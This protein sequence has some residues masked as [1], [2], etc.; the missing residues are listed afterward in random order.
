MWLCSIRVFYKSFEGGA[1]PSQTPV[2]SPTLSKKLSIHTAERFPSQNPKAFSKINQTI[3][4][5]S[6]ECQ[7]GQLEGLSKMLRAPRPQNTI[8]TNLHTQQLIPY[9]K[10]AQD[11]TKI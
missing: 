8:P 5:S 4:N 9:T 1:G 10:K 7:A 3:P 6:A 2:L 11:S